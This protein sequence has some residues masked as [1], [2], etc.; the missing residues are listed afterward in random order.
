MHKLLEQ[1]QKELLHTDDL[2][3]RPF[4]LHG[5]QAQLMYIETLCDKEKLEVSVFKQWFQ[6]NSSAYPNLEVNQLLTAAN[7]DLISTSL[8]GIH[9]L[10][11][12]KGL[13]GFDHSEDLFAFNAELSNVRSI[14]EPANELS[15]VGERAGFVEHLT[16]NLNLIRI[17]ASVK[18]FQVSYLSVGKQGTHKV[19]IVWVDG[20]AEDQIVQET[21]SRLSAFKSSLE[22]HPGKLQKQLTAQKSIFPQVFGTERIDIATSLLLQGR[23]AILCDQSS[24]CLIVPASFYTFLKSA[25]AILLGFGTAWLLQS[26]RAVGLFL[27]LYICS[28]YIATTTFHHEILPA[29]MTINIKSSLENVPYPPIIEAI[30]MIL[31]FQLIAEATIRLPSQLAQMVGV[32]GGIII[33]ESLVKIGF[34]SN[35]FIVIVSLSMIGSFMI[36]TYQMRVS[37]LGIQVLL[38]IGATVMG[39]YGIMFV[40]IAILIHFFTLE[41][42]GV[43]YCMPV[44]SKSK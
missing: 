20:I 34:V 27:S 29:K 19:A 14:Q 3:I 2:I 12:G 31:I 25:D 15:I 10:M 9:A 1:I 38:L 16:V 24:T 42:F 18:S 21:I 4:E 41:P 30:I 22:V 28:L 33:S 37:T 6:T 35:V 5:A 23:V 39:F 36:P 32:T 13:I 40:T 44:R 7:N 17:R 11:Q 43:P 26:L 8:D